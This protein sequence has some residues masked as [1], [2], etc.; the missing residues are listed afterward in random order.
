M[1]L[2]MNFTNTLAGGAVGG[3][4]CLQRGARGLRVRAVVDCG[5][6]DFWLRCILWLVKKRAG[7]YLSGSGFPETTRLCLS[8]VQ[9][10]RDYY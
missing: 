9:Q 10:S 6:D 4:R 1:N 5:Y 3:Q 2:R 8:G 7:R